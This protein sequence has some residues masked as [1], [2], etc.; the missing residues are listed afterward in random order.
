[1]NVYFGS[2]LDLSIVNPR[3]KLSGKR[4]EVFLA[5]KFGIDL[6]TDGSFTLS[7]KPE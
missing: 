3:F 7:G 2:V 6:K 1:M 4:S 5:T